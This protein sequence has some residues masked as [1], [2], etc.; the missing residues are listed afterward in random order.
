MV[1]KMTI[2]VQTEEG[3]Q[4]RKQEAAEKVVIDFKV[5]R[6]VKYYYLHLRNG[7]DPPLVFHGETD[8]A[9]STS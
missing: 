2:Y 6:S 1:F 8:R 7:T 9:F 4:I 3:K 5:L